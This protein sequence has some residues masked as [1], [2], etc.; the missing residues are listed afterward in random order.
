MILHEIFTKH[1]REFARTRPS[2]NLRA[3]R[4][5]FKHVPQFRQPVEI[6]DS[7]G[8]IPDG[9]WLVRNAVRRWGVLYGAIRPCLGGDPC[10]RRLIS[11]IAEREA[12]GTKLRLRYVRGKLMREAGF[13]DE[14]RKQVL[15]E[16]VLAGVLVKREAEW[17][18]GARGTVVS[19]NRRHAWV[20]PILGHQPSAA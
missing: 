2:A 17:S 5:S 7:Q 18:N 11:L 8:W 20:R 16:L 4:D 12:R 3:L 13:C 6:L 19:L 14:E 15:A 1:V 10:T 9:H